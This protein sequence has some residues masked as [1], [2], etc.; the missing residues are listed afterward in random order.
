M[1][2]IS[3]IGARPQFIKC[4][5]LSKEIRKKHTEILVHT[6]Q[7]YDTHLSDIFFKELTIPQ[8]DYNLGVGSGT[9]GKQ[10]GEMLIRLDK[11]YEKENPDLVMVYGDTNSTLAGALAAVKMQIPVAHVE[12]GLRSYDRAMPEEINRVAVDHMSDY[13]LCPTTT[14][15]MNLSCEGRN[16]GVY[17]VGDVSVDTLLKYKDSAESKSDIIEQLKKRVPIT[18]KEYNLLTIHR[19]GNT[20]NRDTL[21]EILQAINDY[22]T[23]TIFPMHPRFRDACY[24]FNINMSDYPNI[25]PIDPVGYFNMLKLMMNSK[26]IV[27]DSGGIQKEAY[28]LGIPCITLRDTTEW[29][30]TV[31]WG[32]NVLA[33]TRTNSI[34]TALS[35]EDPHLPRLDIFPAG[36]SKRI[37]SEVLDNIV[38]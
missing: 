7:H 12:A 29:Q 36:A 4:A 19:Q 11:V 28:I 17:K 16:W 1:K 21:A 34:L 14:A 32:W 6:G 3:V 18:E 13:L 22:G 10:T 30:E 25:Y 5:E 20:N 8:P 38:G 31:G 2:I 26:K 24:T 9:H 27:T 37:V 15:V 33:G 23:K 35:L